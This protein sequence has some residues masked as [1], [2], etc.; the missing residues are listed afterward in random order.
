MKIWDW[1]LWWWWIWL[2]LTLVHMRERRG[3]GEVREWSN[4]R[5]GGGECWLRVNGATQSA[6][7]CTMCISGWVGIGRERF[8]NV[9]SVWGRHPGRGYTGDRCSPTLID[10]LPSHPCNINVGW[11]IQAFWWVPFF[12]HPEY[13]LNTTKLSVYNYFTVV[14]QYKMTQKCYQY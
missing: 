12:Y 6:T 7:C 4:L 13:S 1:Y 3:W 5:I 9:G 8:G 11:V 2:P 14:T 10:A